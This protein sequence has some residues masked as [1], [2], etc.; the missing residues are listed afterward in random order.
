[1]TQFKE[2][3][4]VKYNPERIED[5]GR[6]LG[7]VVEISTVHIADWNHVVPPGHTVIGVSWPDG[8]MEEDPE[9]LL[10]VTEDDSV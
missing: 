7:L 1:M 5:I 10:K 3:D 9:D 8:Y 6:L 4:L 2:G